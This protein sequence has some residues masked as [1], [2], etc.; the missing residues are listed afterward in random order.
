MHSGNAAAIPEVRN[1][2][3][4]SFCHASRSVRITTAILVSNC[5]YHP[6]VVPGWSEGLDLRCASAHRGIPRFSDVQLHIVVRCFASPRNDGRQNTAFGPAVEP[7]VS[8][9]LHCNGGTMRR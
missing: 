3:T 4:L 1:D 7:A 5:M 2:A 8:G 9:W 6:D